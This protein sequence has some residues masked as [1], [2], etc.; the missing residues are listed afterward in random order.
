MRERQAMAGVAMVT[1]NEVFKLASRPSG[2]L[3]TGGAAYAEKT[4]RLK[5]TGAIEGANRR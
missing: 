1:S 5:I 2:T 4:G 3:I